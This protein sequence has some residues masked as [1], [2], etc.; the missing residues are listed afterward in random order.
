MTP[1]TAPRVDSLTQPGAA[2]GKDTLARAEDLGSTYPLVCNYG[3]QYPFGVP[4][5]CAVAVS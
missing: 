2:A 5:N 1:W 4:P 3:P